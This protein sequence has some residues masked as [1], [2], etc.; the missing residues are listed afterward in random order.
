[1]SI[2]TKQHLQPLSIPT[3]GFSPIE[4]FVINNKVS[5]GQLDSLLSYV[6]KLCHLS[7]GHLD[8]YRSSRI[9]SNSINL[10]GLTDV[11]LKLRSVSFHKFESLVIEFFSSSPNLTFCIILY[12]FFYFGF[13]RFQRWSMGTINFNSYAKSLCLRL[14]R[15]KSSISSQF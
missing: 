12:L 14:S 8:G 13:K 2:E 15:G 7:F 1:M 6:P 9:H 5:L 3:S 4:H 10:N 11:S